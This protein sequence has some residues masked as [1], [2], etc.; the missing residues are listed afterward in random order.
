[1]LWLDL[2]QY[3]LTVSPDTSDKRK[4][5][6]RAFKPLRRGERIDI[7]A[8]SSALGVEVVSDPDNAHHALIRGWPSLSAWQQAFPDLKQRWTDLGP[9]D[10]SQPYHWLY[11]VDEAN[12]AVTPER[13]AHLS[14]VQLFA[15]TKHLARAHGNVATPVPVRSVRH[16][17]LGDTPG[18]FWGVEDGELDAP[19]EDQIRDDLLTLADKVQDW[20]AER[21]RSADP[22]DTDL[23][24]DQAPSGEQPVSGV[25]PSEPPGP[26]EGQSTA[27]PEGGLDHQRADYGEVIPM[28]RKHLHASAAMGLLAASADD[29]SLILS[30]FDT[31]VTLTEAKRLHEQARALARRFKRDQIWPAPNPVQDLDKEGAPSRDPIIALMESR[32]HASV[33]PSTVGL[34]N[35]RRRH[36]YVSPHEWIRLGAGYVALVQGLRDRF[37]QGYE[38][39]EHFISEGFAYDRSLIEMESIGWRN[40]GVPAT[41]FRGDDDPAFALSLEAAAPGEEFAERI[42]ALSQELP[43]SL[44]HDRVT[45]NVTAASGFTGIAYDALF[46]TAVSGAGEPA[47]LAREKVEALSSSESGDSHLFNQLGRNWSQWPVS[48]YLLVGS[49]RRADLLNRVQRAFLDWA[50]QVRALDLEPKDLMAALLGAE[51]QGKPSEKASGNASEKASDPAEPVAKPPPVPSLK[52]PVPPR[53]ENLERVGPDRREGDV[54]EADLLSRFG[55]RGVQYGNWVNQK[56]RQF[57]LNATYDSMADMAQALGVPDRFM[58]LHGRLGLALGARGQGGRAAAHYER[59]LK[60]LNLT[61]TMGAGAT[62]HE[63]VHAL[64]HWLGERAGRPMDY[65]S[66]MVAGNPSRLWSEDSPPEGDDPGALMRYFI[67]RCVTY[68]SITEAQAVR[69]AIQDSRALLALNEFQ[70]KI[71]SPATLARLD[72]SE[73]AA[74]WGS[75][76]EPWVDHLKTHGATVLFEPRG[77][78]LVFSRDYLETSIKET[79]EAA[80][81][82]LNE[83]EQAYLSTWVGYGIEYKDARKFYRASGKIHYGSTSTLFMSSARLLDGDKDG[84]YWSSPHELVARALSTVIH[85]RMAIE[86]V[87]NDFATRY[88]APAQ[89]TLER[90][91][92]ASSNPEG[93]EVE[94][95]VTAAE[96]LLNAVQALAERLEAEAGPAVLP[97]EKSSEDGQ[98]AQRRAAA[99]QSN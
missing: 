8:I 7:E 83:E 89:F 62:A 48:A 76:L 5:K 99:R 22:A 3:G 87:R 16:L 9:D 88:S 74:S 29:E 32:A 30:R 85:E 47:R 34:L 27:T 64:D 19:D 14:S 31:Q 25:A 93:P 72:S 70:R 95:V 24:S 60:V 51:D 65:L 6:I 53:Y 28:A 78:R 35:P 45:G 17:G 12:P 15:A 94:R 67:A 58:G 90:G 41:W 46:Y 52:N 2:S 23:A 98:G 57:M 84:K 54:T 97:E 77:G 40:D 73:I 42:Y 49:E 11:R 21:A 33:Y 26:D 4:L 43:L 96:P 63:W 50:A 39:P 13:P 10:L 68:A 55:F 75:R 80:G 71:F 44:L 79:M 38:D 91:Y 61:K 66:G 18:T 20:F 86:G 81:K 36:S 92:R 82:P 59:G 69:Q 56:E 1:M 37:S